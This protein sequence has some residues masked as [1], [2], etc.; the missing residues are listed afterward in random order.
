MLAAPS[1][2]RPLSESRESCTGVPADSVPP[3]GPGTVAPRRDRRGFRV[4]LLF[5]FGLWQAVAASLSARPGPA[6]PDPAIWVGRIG[7]RGPKN[8]AN[9]NQDTFKSSEAWATGT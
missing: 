7:H 6:R 8:R 5:K 4:R 3:A 2:Q 9:L 1:A